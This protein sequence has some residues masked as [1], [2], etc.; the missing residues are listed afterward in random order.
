MMKLPKARITLDIDVELLRW[1]TE[2]A[3]AHD[4]SRNEVIGDAVRYYKAQK[5][6]ELMQRRGNIND[7]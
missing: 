5:D 2:Y 7:Q 3:E 4:K 6:N 1:V